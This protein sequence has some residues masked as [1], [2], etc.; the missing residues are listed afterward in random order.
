MFGKNFEQHQAIQFK[1]EKFHNLVRRDKI[2]LN[3]V[4]D[5]NYNCFIN[6]HEFRKCSEFDIFVN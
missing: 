4:K 2:S 6:L 1:C 5:S 3:L